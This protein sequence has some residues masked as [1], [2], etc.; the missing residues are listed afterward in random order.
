MIINFSGGVSETGIRGSF[1]HFAS[2]SALVR[3]YSEEMGMDARSVVKLT[4]RDIFDMSRKKDRVATLV[5]KENAMLVGIGLS[6]L[7]AIFAPEVIV[8]GGGMAEAGDNYI[9][10]VR[11]SAFSNSLENCRA[12]VRIE[13]AALGSNSALIGA[14]FYSLTRLAGLTI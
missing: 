14:A 13:K 9:R 2:A 3:R 8:L 6:N 7:I 12:E 5:V 11:Q 1:E 10:M 4:A